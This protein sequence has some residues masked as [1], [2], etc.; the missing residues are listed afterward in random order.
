[1]IRCRVVHL[2]QT[3]SLVDLV[4]GILGRRRA[5][6]ER[7][8]DLGCLT[9]TLLFDLEQHP[10]AAKGEGYSTYGSQQKILPTANGYYY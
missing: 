8:A 7:L 6:I 5:V 2:H 3:H 9:K 10:K 4:S 1:M